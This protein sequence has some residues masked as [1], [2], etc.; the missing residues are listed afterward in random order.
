ME[1]KNF[2]HEESLL[3][4]NKMIERTQNNIQKGA[5]NRMIFWGAG[6][7]A[8]AVAN[9]ILLQ[10]LPTPYHS[11][12][13]WAFT[14]V[15]SVFQTI[16]FKKQT[17][18][19]THIDS[20]IQTTWIT[21]GIGVYVF[22]MIVFGA[23]ILHGKTLFWLITPVIL[24]F[25]GMAMFITATSCKF[26][27]FFWGATALWTGALF[28]VTLTGSPQQFLILAVCS[29]LGQMFPGIWI[30]KKAKKDV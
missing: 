14:L 8:I 18:V 13:V 11:Y 26:S 20:I 7:A 17:L 16:F 23:F 21:F 25:W 27:P 22:L 5:G 24:L 29:V 30:N 9:Y 12:W 10:I 2:S 19:K 4:I 15:M 6:I 3:I 1:N 28:C